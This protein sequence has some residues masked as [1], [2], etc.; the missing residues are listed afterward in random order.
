MP[1][2]LPKTNELVGKIKPSL[3]S[4][5]LLLSPFELRLLARE[6]DKIDVPHHRWCIQGLLAFLNEND[7]EGI[8]LCEQAVAYD[9]NVSQSWC[10]YASALR[11]RHLLSK[12]W[13][14]VNR[15]VEYKGLL[16]LSY[17]HTLA[18]YWVDIELLNH[19]TEIIES[20][21]MP[22]RFNKVQLD[23][24]GSGMVTRQLLRDAGP[25]VAS[26]LRALGA[27]VRQIA[28]EERLPRLKRRI[29]CHEGEYACVYAIDTDDVDY[30]IRLD[31]L[32]FNRI[33]SAGIKSKNCIAFFEPKLGD[34][35]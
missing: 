11:Y 26:D 6:A 17:A 34:D 10:N 19:T 24:F 18:S 29:S 3:V 7:E 2:A 16:T 23:L 27:V 22:K 33:V 31:D 8:A 14:V 28:E 32:L 21:E 1:L 12:E 4:G 35:N 15:S 9:P 25:A 13:E 20:M 5:E 30:L